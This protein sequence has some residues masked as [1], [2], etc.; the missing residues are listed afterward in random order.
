VV[1][2]FDAG[3]AL[4]GGPGEGGQDEWVAMRRLVSRF[5]GKGS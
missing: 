4:Q 1:T 3:K 5:E 2:V